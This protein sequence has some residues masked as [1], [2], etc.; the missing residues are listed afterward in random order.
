MLRADTVIIHYTVSADLLVFV[1]RA[2]FGE[3]S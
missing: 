2:Q 3:A 1:L